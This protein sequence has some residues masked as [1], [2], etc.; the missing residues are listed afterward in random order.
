[1]GMRLLWPFVNESKN[2]LNQSTR[3]IFPFRLASI[4]RKRTT[5]PGMSSIP[6][7]L[8]LF[9]FK[10]IT[11]TISTIIAS[12]ECNHHSHLFF[13][14]SLLSADAKQHQVGDL[15]EMGK[16][17][18]G[19]LI[20]LRAL[21]WNHRVSLAANR[22]VDPWTLRLSRWIANRQTTNENWGNLERE[23]VC[24]E[25]ERESDPPK[26]TTDVRRLLALWWRNQGFYSVLEWG[27]GFR[28]GS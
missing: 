23:L 27:V 28:G 25:R 19:T 2:V 1:M 21:R 12:M 17:W 5:D 16:S 13:S 6:I 14:L 22:L 24:F 3:S 10:L 20:S 15:L 8:L 4:A 26:P 7:P 9:F 11:G 18:N